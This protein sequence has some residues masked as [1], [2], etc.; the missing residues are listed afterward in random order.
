M[1]II[2]YFSETVNQE[3][4]K[5][6]EKPVLLLG[7]NKNYHG[8]NLKI[9]NNFITA[10]ELKE[11]LFAFNL[12]VLPSVHK[13]CFIGSLLELNVSFNHH[14]PKCF[15]HC[16]ILSLQSFHNMNHLI[17]LASITNWFI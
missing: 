15:H 3:M 2:L 14:R 17:S 16:L 10:F 8:K 4:D 9:S 6:T 1:I 11:N 12:N 7:T 5:R 13:F